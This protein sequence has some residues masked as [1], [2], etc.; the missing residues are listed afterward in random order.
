MRIHIEPPRIEYTP[1]E[2]IWF[3]LGGALGEGWNPEAHGWALEARLPTAKE[4]P[5]LLVRP[6]SLPEDKTWA[7]TDVVPVL[8][9]RLR[10]MWIRACEDR[11]GSGW[12]TLQKSAAPLAAI[13]TTL[14]SGP[15]GAPRKDAE[16][17]V[18]V[19]HYTLRMH[20]GGT[21]YPEAPA[22]LLQQIASAESN[23]VDLVDYADSDGGPRR[24]RGL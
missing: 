13:R 8:P 22:D 17:I 24:K 11:F 19:C 16:E 9:I 5:K 3:L 15:G 6:A 2:A 12:Y 1:A 10:T 4:A 7:V 21:S 23:V 20:R 14:F 18:D